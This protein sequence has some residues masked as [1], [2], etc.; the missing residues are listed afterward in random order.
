MIKNIVYFF[1]IFSFSFILFSEEIENVNIFDGEVFINSNSLNFRKEPSINSEKLGSFN[2]GEKVEIIQKSGQIDIINN[3]KNYWYQVKHAN[4]VGWV[5]GAY[6]IKRLENFYGTYE[7]IYPNN[8]KTLIENHYIVIEKKN[9]IV[10]GWYYG[11]T[12]DFD[13]GREGYLPGFFVK[14]V[15]NLSISNNT[16]SFKLFVSEKECYTEPISL[17]YKKISDFPK[18]KYKSW[19]EAVLSFKP[20]E[21]RG[22]IKNNE[23]VLKVWNK[24]RIFK[25][26]N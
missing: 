15:T 8:T 2:Y 21:Y 17:K 12:D 16:I 25:K 22:I 5:F 3:S 1:C 24:D 9:D 11:T 6:L 20:K 26:I 10:N 14:E 18:N 23:I 19:E 13:M 4:K 7:Y